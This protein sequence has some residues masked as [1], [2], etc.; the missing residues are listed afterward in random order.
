[1][2]TT[3]SKRPAAFFLDSAFRL[4]SKKENQRTKA[5]SVVR[6]HPVKTDK[7]NKGAVCCFFT[8]LYFTTCYKIEGKR[9]TNELEQES[10]LEDA[11]S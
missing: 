3:S 10:W 11:V 8:F 6:D 2:A 1:M 9:R 4:T 7:D 5:G